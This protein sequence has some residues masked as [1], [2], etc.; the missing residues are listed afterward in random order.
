MYNLNLIF[1][2]FMAGGDLVKNF[3]KA[4]KKSEINLLLLDLK[5]NLLQI[6]SSRIKQ[7]NVHKQVMD[8]D[9]KMV[10]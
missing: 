2:Q 8:E 6:F 10:S 3:K 4:L 1:I 7:Q 5:N 9:V